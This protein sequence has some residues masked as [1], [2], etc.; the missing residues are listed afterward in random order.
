MKRLTELSKIR[1]THISQSGGHGIITANNDVPLKKVEHV[2]LTFN[3]GEKITNLYDTP[4]H[5]QLNQ[6]LLPD[7][8]LQYRLG[9]NLI[10][11]S[12]FESF[13]SFT[14]LERGWLYDRPS[15]VVNK[16]GASGDKS[17]A[18]LLDKE[19]LTTFGMQ[20]FK[21]VFERSSQM[22]IKAKFKT[23]NTIKVNYYWQG[24]KTRQKLFDAFN[25]G[26]K[27]LIK[28]IELTSNSNWQDIEVDFNSPRIGYKSYRV[29]LEFELVNNN[30]GKI[31][32]DDFSLIEWQ[33]AFS[34]SAKPNFFNVKSQQPSFI[35]LNE[36]TDKSI[37]LRY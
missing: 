15:L 28:S 4:W 10:N 7:S 34:T 33:N 18:L 3:K 9:T 30:N 21:R 29:L 14:G 24:R 8:Q 35:G 2:S 19:K 6:V 32:I 25:N 12:N 20:S 16:Y 31:D 23:N 17:L 36:S 1:N 37:K 13:E 5:T 22:T 26:K 27:H 11:G